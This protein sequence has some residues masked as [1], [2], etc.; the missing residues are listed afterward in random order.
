MAIRK[1]TA[2]IVDVSQNRGLTDLSIIGVPGRY[3]NQRPVPDSYPVKFNPESRHV[4]ELMLQSEE[5]RKKVSGKTID[6]TWHIAVVMF[7][8]LCADVGAFPFSQGNTGSKNEYV[9]D[10]M[11][12]GRI[13]VKQFYDRTGIFKTEAVRLGYRRYERTE[14][15]F[16]VMS[17]AN[18][19]P[20]KNMK[21]EEELQRPHFP[22]FIRG[23]ENRYTRFIRPGVT[24]WVVLKNTY[25]PVIGFTIEIQGNVSIPG[26][27]SPT[28]RE[29]DDFID[30]TMWLPIIRAHRLD[31]VTTR[32][33]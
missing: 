3:Q 15:G 6:L 28:R 27:H 23:V 11:R 2:E 19:Y 31:G 8:G 33:F 13:L 17:W 21:L 4:W 25:R 7:L 20:L 30:D 9:R 10:V 14:N 16:R 22:R 5:Y 18:L 32:L 1:E 29:V 12:R 26:R 24:A